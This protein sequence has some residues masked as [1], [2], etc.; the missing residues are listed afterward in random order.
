MVW[1][2][3]WFE[4]CSALIKMLPGR[5]HKLQVNWMEEDGV[6]ALEEIRDRY[7]SQVDN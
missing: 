2:R 7:L 1:D 6:I 3:E 4:N 5:N